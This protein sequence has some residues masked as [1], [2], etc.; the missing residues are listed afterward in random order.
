MEC[1][2]LG[3]DP[4]WPS[5]MVAI[6]AEPTA[7]CVGH[8]DLDQAIGME[9]LCAWSHSAG[10]AIVGCMRHPDGIGAGWSDHFRLSA[11]GTLERKSSRDRVGDRP[12]SFDSSYLVLDGCLL[13]TVFARTSSGVLLQAAMPA[14]IYPIVMTRMFDSDMGT[15]IRTSVGTN[16]V[17]IVTIPIWVLVGRSILSI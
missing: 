16:L 5:P 6:V 10:S 14:A 12:S 11:E 9:R 13:S 15:A 1:G 2:A 17:A 7:D 4:R 3:I 8:F